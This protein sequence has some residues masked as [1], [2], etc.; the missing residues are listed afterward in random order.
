[1]YVFC[2][3]YVCLMYVFNNNNNNNIGEIMDSRYNKLEI[4]ILSCL[5]QKPK[6]MNKIFISDDDFVYHKR[7]WLFMKS[8]YNKFGNF[9]LV[10]MNSVCKNSFK[11]A[12]YVEQLMDATLFLNDEQFIDYQNTL[13]DLKKETK[14]D[15][16]IIDKCF[17]L[18]NE[19]YVKNIDTLEFKNGIEKI[20]NEAEIIFKEEQ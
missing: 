14:K 9:D 17:R 10:L 20:Y 13:L 1:M 8:F 19:L 7:F 11:F 15:S 4:N 18:A 16:W 2:M 6:L 3:F 5:I 12:N